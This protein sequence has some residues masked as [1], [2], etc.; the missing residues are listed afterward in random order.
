MS[1]SVSIVLPTRN[2][3]ATLPSVLDA[4]HRQ[5]LERPLEVVAVDSGSTD[6]TLDALRGRVDHLIRIAPD[7][8]DHG[9]T[10]N[11]GIEQAHGDVI[12]LLV[13]D[14]VPASD[15]WLAALIAP[16]VGDSTG[17]VAGAFARQVPRVDA[18]PITRHYLA[19]W[20]A[21]SEVPRSAA[22]AGRTELDAL[23]PMARLERCTFDNVCSC[24]RR[25]VWLEHPFRAT[26]IAED[27]EWARDVLLAGYRI[28][29]APTAVV[30]HSHD[31]SARYEFDRTRLLHRRLYELF[32]VRTIPT[33]PHLARAMLS[34]LAM[35]LRCER[36]GRAVAL[37]VAWPLGQYVG[38][39]SAARGWKPFRVQNV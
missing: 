32:G 5:R 10:R 14:A 25:S 34:S 22:I 37:A 8:F 18:S 9:T 31:R 1:A 6:G 20:M 15:T 26:P 33:V 38:A 4:I 13:Q 21:A 7:T 17:R 11:L 27:L 12:V 39:L 23:D 16:V 35:H 3:I 29:Y 24:I 36:S 19:R 30:V 2:G 28:M